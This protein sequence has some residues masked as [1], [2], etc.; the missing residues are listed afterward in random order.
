M[1]YS[2]AYWR[3]NGQYWPSKG[4]ISLLDHYNHEEIWAGEVSVQLSIQL[5][6]LRRLLAAHLLFWPS[7]RT[8]RAK[9]VSIA[10]RPEERIYI[11]LDPY[12]NVIVP[13]CE[14][15]VL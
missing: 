15:T 10:K 5:G 1:S 9:A 4:R 6:V 13:Y 11:H 3:Q 12:R 2:L 14:R 8:T 7:P